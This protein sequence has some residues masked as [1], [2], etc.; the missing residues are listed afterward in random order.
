MLRLEPYQDLEQLLQVA[1]DQ[2]VV[3]VKSPAALLRVVPVTGQVAE[4]HLQPLFVVAHLT[5]GQRRTQI[6]RRRETRIRANPPVRPID[7]YGRA[8]LHLP[9]ASMVNGVKSASAEV[10]CARH[11]FI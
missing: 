3:F 6:L 9:Q 5:L 2:A 7:Q 8:A 4:Y 11:L 1:G 10:L